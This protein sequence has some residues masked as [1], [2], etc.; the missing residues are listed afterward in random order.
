M[1]TEL[2]PETHSILHQAQMSSPWKIW[3]SFPCHVLSEYVL[4]VDIQPM[5]L[6]SMKQQNTRYLGGVGLTGPSLLVWA[7][8]SK[9]RSTTISVS[10]KTNVSSADKHP[11]NVAKQ[12]SNT[13]AILAN[14]LGGAAA[15]RLTGRNS[16][17]KFK[18]LSHPLTDMKSRSTNSPYVEQASQ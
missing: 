8:I 11:Q 16:R 18:S 3:A 10:Y 1:S 6:S 7:A 13:I 9:L 5:F 2:G 4:C 15:Q 17:R 14:F 12:A